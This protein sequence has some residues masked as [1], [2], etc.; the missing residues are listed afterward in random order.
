MLSSKLAS[1]EEVLARGSGTSLL[2]FEKNVLITSEKTYYYEL[3][4]SANDDI[5]V[6]KA[7]KKLQFL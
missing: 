4:G 1:P 2:I 5:T 6:F 7:T 3:I